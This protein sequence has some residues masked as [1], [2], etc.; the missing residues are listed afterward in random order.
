[1]IFTSLCLRLILTTT[2]DGATSN[3]VSFITQEPDSHRVFLRSYDASSG[4]V[5]DVAWTDLLADDQILDAQKDTPSA[6]IWILSKHGANGRLTKFHRIGNLMKALKDSRNLQKGRFQSVLPLGN[7]ATVLWMNSEFDDSESNGLSR[8]AMLARDGRTII[9]TDSRSFAG[10][11]SGWIS[12]FLISAGK[13]RL[14]SQLNFMDEVMSVAQTK[15]H[16]VLMRSNWGWN[17]LKVT[18]SSRLVVERSTLT[19]NNQWQNMWANSSS[20]RVYLVRNGEIATASVASNG[21]VSLARN[22]LKVSLGSEEIWSAKG[23]FVGDHLLLFLQG[24]YILNVLVMPSGDL[25]VLGKKAV[26][27]VEIWPI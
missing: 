4:E 5:K 1:M 12:S 8:D 9:V 27:S 2:P 23:R 25:K 13:L 14:K 3:V 15:G 24:G 17:S 7:I 26:G 16:L 22:T 20:D 11:S 10:S 6:D 21:N 18:P 19:E